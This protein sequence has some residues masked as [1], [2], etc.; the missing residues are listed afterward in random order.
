MLPQSARGSNARDM[1][2]L[3]TPNCKSNQRPPP[4]LNSTERP[5][6]QTQLK[7]NERIFSQTTRTLR[8]DA[9]QACLDRRPSPVSNPADHYHHTHASPTTR[10]HRHRALSPRSIHHIECPPPLL[11][12]SAPLDSSTSPPQHCTPRQASCASTQLAKRRASL[13]RM[14]VDSSVSCC[15]TQASSLH[16]D[17]YFV[18]TAWWSRRPSQQQ[19]TRSGR[20]FA[21]ERTR[22]PV[23]GV[24]WET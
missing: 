6:P 14:C 12:C 23:A 1:D 5:P 13:N 16:L 20:R 7:C 9:S 24:Q 17:C 18:R 3:R 11:R 15:R 4:N 19:T 10:T 21:H 22:P 2:Q 8:I